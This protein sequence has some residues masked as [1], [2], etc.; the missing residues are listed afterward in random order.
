MQMHDKPY[1]T[2]DDK[3][4]NTGSKQGLNSGRLLNTSQLRHF[5]VQYW[6]SIKYN[7]IPHIQYCSASSKSPPSSQKVTYLAES[8]ETF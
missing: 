1:I 2:V 7:V 8:G 4:R 6:L 5:I 3:Y